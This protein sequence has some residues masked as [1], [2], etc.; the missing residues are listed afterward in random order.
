[1]KVTKSFTLGEDTIKKL[2]EFSHKEYSTDSASVDKIINRYID[3]HYK[4]EEIK[5]IQKIADEKENKEL[6]DA[7]PSDPNHVTP[8]QFDKVDVNGGEPAPS[9][10]KSST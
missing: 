3:R 10:E 4:E 9:Y 6:M 7:I 2:K 8:P 5:K 1:M